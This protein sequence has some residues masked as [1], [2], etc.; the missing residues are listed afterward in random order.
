MS[1]FSRS[2]WNNAVLVQEAW[3]KD[4]TSTAGK[5]PR[6]ISE[7]SCSTLSCAKP[8]KPFSTCRGDTRKSLGVFRGRFCVARMSRASEK[9]STLKV[10]VGPCG[11][12]AT[13]IQVAVFVE[14]KMT[15][16]VTWKCPATATKSSIRLCRDSLSLCAQFGLMTCRKSWMSALTRS[17]TVPRLMMKHRGVSTLSF[18]DASSGSVCFLFLLLPIAAR[19]RLNN[20]RRCP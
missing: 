2:M 11:I 15:M 19:L 6:S 4:G 14:L 13:F 10:R 16:W 7:V 5:R 9:L 8:P 1:S 20:R 12:L 3:L 17:P 18:S